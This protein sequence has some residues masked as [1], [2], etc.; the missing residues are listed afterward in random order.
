MSTATSITVRVPLAIRHRRGR[1][2]VVMPDGQGGTPTTR[3]RSDSTMVKALARAF[4]WK[5]LLEAGRYSSISEI[6]AAEKIDRGYVGNILRLT[7]LAPDTVEAI[8][9]GRQ[10]DGLGMPALLEPFPLEWGQQRIHWLVT[11]DRLGEAPDLATTG[12]DS[13]GAFSPRC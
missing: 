6:A 3:T 10:P 1:R 8:M 5:R 7:L 13:T 9:D 2:T 4:R 12:S 11:A